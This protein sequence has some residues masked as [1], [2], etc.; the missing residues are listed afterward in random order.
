[1]ALYADDMLLFLPSLPAAIKCVN[2][3]GRFSGLGM[4]WEKS[5]L[6]PLDLLPDSLPPSLSHIK[7]VSSIKYLGITMS[8]FPQA[9]IADNIAPLLSR[10][11]IQIQIWSKLP[12]SV[13][14]LTYLR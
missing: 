4:N 6:L 13:V 5:M 9:F 8:A 3:F 12:L 11:H 2:E 1:M 14:G 10:F 7:V